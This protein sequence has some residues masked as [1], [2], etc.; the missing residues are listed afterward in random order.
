M[1]ARAHTHDVRTQRVHEGHARTQRTHAHIF[2]SASPA[3]LVPQ[4]LQWK[5]EVDAT[6]LAHVVSTNVGATHD[7]VLSAVIAE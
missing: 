6:A 4:E 1:D 7:V 3:P 2:D 5:S